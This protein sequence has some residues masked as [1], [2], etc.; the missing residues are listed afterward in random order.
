LEL[1]FAGSRML[2]DLLAAEGSKIGR[3]H[4]TTLMRKMGIEG[5]RPM[6]VLGV[7]RRFPLDGARIGQRR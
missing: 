3:R 2:R 4:A 6:N 1:P 5:K 7:V